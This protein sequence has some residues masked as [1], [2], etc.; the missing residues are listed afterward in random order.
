MSFS[1]HLLDGRGRR[2]IAEMPMNSWRRP[3]AGEDSGMDSG[4]VKLFSMVSSVEGAHAEGK[5]ITG[6]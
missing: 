3:E 5:V 6:K 4:N 2:G 1:D